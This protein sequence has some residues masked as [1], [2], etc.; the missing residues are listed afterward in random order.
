MSQEGKL[1][2][3][4]LETTIRALNAASFRA[5]Q[6]KQVV[7]KKIDLGAIEKNLEQLYC[8]LGKRIAD[9]HQIGRKN[10]LEEQ[11]TARLLDNLLNLKQAATLLAEEIELIRTEQPA[12]DKASKSAAAEDDSAR[13]EL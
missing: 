5:N 1:S 7:Q 4:I 2:G 13:Q 12:A 8:E 6:Y 10:I 3:R 9:L 11:E